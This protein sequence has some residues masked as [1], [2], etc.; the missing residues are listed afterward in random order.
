[1]KGEI[2]S[3][4][5]VVALIAGAGI[6]YLG[7]S[8]FP[9]TVTKTIVTTLTQGSGLEECSVTEYHVWSV[10][11]IYNSTT[12]GG[13]STQSY[14]VTTFQT[15][16]YPTITTNTYTGTL[17]GAIAYW[18]ATSC[19]GV[20][21]QVQYPVNFVGSPKSCSIQG[22]CVNATLQSRIG[23]NLTVMLFGWYQNATTGQ[24]ET[25]GGSSNSMYATTCKATV[26]S[27]HCYLIAYPESRGAFRVTLLVRATD[28]TT[29]L[30]TDESVV[31]NY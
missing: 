16:G 2:A 1:L 24:N 5:V 20:N 26:S 9:T 11:S 12:M 17:T 7:G 3:V 31:V 6:G 28:G 10:E 18:N 4:L 21:S 30:S 22:L 15:S 27:S 23:E 14:P 19:S 8:A 29:A 25:I 13:T